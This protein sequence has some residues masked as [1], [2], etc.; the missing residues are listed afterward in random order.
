MYLLC[1]L[2]VPRMCASLGERLLCSLLERSL[3]GQAYPSI[4]QLTESSVLLSKKSSDGPQ[5]P[6]RFGN[7][8]TV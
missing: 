1:H 8:Q 3:S 4:K 6:V 2:S 7:G 5:I